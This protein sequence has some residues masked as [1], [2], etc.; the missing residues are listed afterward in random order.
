MLKRMIVTTY[1]KSH[2]YLYWNI[3]WIESRAMSALCLN[4]QKHPATTKCI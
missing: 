4:G 2:K 3:E 1:R